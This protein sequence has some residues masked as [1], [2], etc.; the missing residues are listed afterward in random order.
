MKLFHA[1]GYAGRAFWM[2][3]TKRHGATA[4]HRGWRRHLEI[5][6]KLALCE[7]WLI[8]CQPRHRWLL[9]WMRRS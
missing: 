1:I 5:A 9:W 6:F 3:A 7:F 2:T 4:R 8:A